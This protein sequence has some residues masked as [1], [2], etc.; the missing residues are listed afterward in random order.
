MVPFRSDTIQLVQNECSFHGLQ[1]EDPN[2]HLKDFLKLVDSLD[3]DGENR[4]RTR[5]HLFQFSLRNQASNWLERLPTGSITTWEDLTTRL[6]AQF[7]PSGRIAKLCNDILIWNDPR[8][9]A[10]PVKAIALPQDVPST[11]DRRLIELENQDDIIGKINLLWKTIFEKL[12][13]VSTPENAGNSM[14]PK[15]IAAI[16]HDEREELRKKAIKSLSKLFSPKYLSLASIKELNKN[17]STPKRVHF[18]NSIVILSKDN[19][20]EEDV[21]KTNARIRDL[22]KMMRGNEEVKEQGKGEDEMETNVEVKE[23]IKEEES[24]FETGEEVEELLKEDEDDE[25]FNSFPTMKEL[26]HHE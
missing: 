23:V 18:V 6:F 14:A 11:S 4:E 7:F 17:P 25:N 10:K 1:S 3:L 8:D 5:L 16:S 15:S 9:F 12:N 2:Q 20:T 22:D 24:E 21:S 26:S 13:G 19:D